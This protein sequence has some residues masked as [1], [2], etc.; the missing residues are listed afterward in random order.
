MLLWPGTSVV[1]F[2]SSEQLA[3]GAASA[4]RPPNIVYFVT[5]DQD[6][7]LGGSF[8]TTA[9]GMATPLPKVRELMVEGGATFENMFI[10]VPICNP[11]RSTTLTGRYFHNIKSSAEGGGGGGRDA[12]GG[13]GPG[14]N[15]QLGDD[16][17]HVDMSRVHNHSF[18][19]RLQRR[20]Y[21]LGLF[22]KY[23]NAMP[24]NVA[25]SRLTRQPP[26]AAVAPR[27]R[28]HGPGR[29]PSS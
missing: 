5:D 15:G 28:S 7:M 27:G 2:A 10:H 29:V 19:V 9:P 17:M 14:G 26:S 3:I 25:S 22:G 21:A 6:Q 1:A 20:G 8:P 13:G 24:G 4:A 12:S 18:A 16:T 23:L 11:S